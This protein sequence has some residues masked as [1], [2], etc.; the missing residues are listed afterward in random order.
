MAPKTLPR[1]R[2]AAQSRGWSHPSWYGT[3]P[4]SPVFYAD[5]GDGDPDPEGGDGA[6]VVEPEPADDW[7]PP[8]REEWEAHQAKLR[9]AS[10]EAAARRKFLRANGIDPKTGQK[11]EPD[12]PEPEPAA[13]PDDKNDEPRGAT[14]A[15]VKRAI[16]RAAAEAELRGRRQTRSLVTGLN[17]ALSDAGW[18]GQ[19]LSSLMKLIDIDDVEIDDD[20]TITGLDE[21]IAEI[22]TEWPEFFKRTRNPANPSSQAGGSGQNGAPAAKVDVADK[23]APKPEPKGWA[24]TLAARALRG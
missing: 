2:P 21:Q 8:T 4:F 13:R 7:T 12:E 18:N 5:G 17:T 23:P 19:R 16:E 9:T 3:S 14:P 6:P 24:E 10:G 22:R 1:Y 15:E 20:G 11:I